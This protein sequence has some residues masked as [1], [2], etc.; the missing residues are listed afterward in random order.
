[1]KV[2]GER[3][4]TTFILVLFFLFILTALGYKFQAKIVPL[5]VAIPGFLLTL[6][7]L[8]LSKVKVAED[9]CDRE[10]L[11]RV[12]PLWLWLLAWVALSFFVGL[13]PASFVFMVLFLRFFSQKS[14]MLSLLTGF[15]VFAAVYLLFHSLLGKL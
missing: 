5:V 15:L 3:I 10:R 7:A 14:W 4:F 11:R 12:F 8:G 1:M 13:L 2:Q 9:S 6:I